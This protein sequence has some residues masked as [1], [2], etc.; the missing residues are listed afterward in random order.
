MICCTLQWPTAMPAWSAMAPESLA[1]YINQ[2]ADI[3]GVCC[4]QCQEA[5]GDDNSGFRRV[6]RAFGEFVRRFQLPDN[7]DPEHI[8]AK[9]ENGARATH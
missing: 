5:E 3:C 4:S 9:V 8:S 7:T 2:Q 1:V 6:E